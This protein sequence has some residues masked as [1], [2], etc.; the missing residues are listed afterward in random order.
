MR[1]ILDNVRKEREAYELL[2]MT[3]TQAIEYLEKKIE[4]EKQKEKENE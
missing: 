3:V 4:E 1:N 2:D